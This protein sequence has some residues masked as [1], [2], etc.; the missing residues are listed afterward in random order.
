MS[1]IAHINGQFVSTLGAARHVHVVDHELVTIVARPGVELGSTSGG[2]VTTLKNLPYSYA[3]RIV[4]AALGVGLLIRRYTVTSEDPNDARKTIMA[5]LLMRLWDC[6]NGRI[7]LDGDDIRDYLLDDLRSRT[8]LVGQDTFLLNDM[9]KANILI[10]R[11]DASDENLNQANANASLED[12]VVSLR[13]GLDTRLGECGARLSAAS[14]SVSP[15]P[16][17]S[18][19]TS[20]SSFSTRRQA[21][22][23]P[24]TRWRFAAR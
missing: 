14:A 4:P 10:V 21:T 15:L 17:L 9:L 11:P 8:A 23:M 16:T 6:D 13:D 7:T 24:S 5:Q 19:R 22:S 3:S 1:E 2:A 12:V 18:S 20:P